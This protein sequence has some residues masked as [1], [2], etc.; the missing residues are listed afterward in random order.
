MCE[1]C[2][3]IDAKIEHYRRMSASITDLQ[4]LQGIETLIAEMEFQKRA[5][6]PGESTSKR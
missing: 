2:V 6:H 1:K 3:Q 5:L 4:T